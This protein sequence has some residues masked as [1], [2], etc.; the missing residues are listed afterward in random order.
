MNVKRLGFMRAGLIR[1]LKTNKKGYKDENGN[2]I[3]A[4]AFADQ[5]LSMDLKD[6]KELEAM[7][8]KKAQEDKD[9]GNNSENKV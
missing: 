2:S 4:E 1:L 7:I 6:A 3:T 8:K 9:N 5:L